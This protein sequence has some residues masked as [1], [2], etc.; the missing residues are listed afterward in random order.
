MKEMFETVFAGSCLSE[1]SPQISHFWPSS[2]FSCFNFFCSHLNGNSLAD[3]FSEL[4]PTH[5]MCLSSPLHPQ[6]NCSRVLPPGKAQP[7]LPPVASA[8][9][10]LCAEDRFLPAADAPCVA[11]SF[12]SAPCAHAGAFTAVHS[13]CRPSWNKQCNAYLIM[14]AIIFK[15]L[16]RP[17]Q[18]RLTLP[19][20][21]S[22]RSVWTEETQTF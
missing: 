11:Y 4:Y 16:L 18:H 14:H 20:F 22:V 7:A 15:S 13:Y 6:L 21:V 19:A 1:K 12:R 8:H 10:L 2:H 17:P 5:L 3:S 9:W